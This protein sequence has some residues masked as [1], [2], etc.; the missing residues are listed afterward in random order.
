MLLRYQI[1]DKEMYNFFKRVCKN[2]WRRK[3][4]ICEECPFK[5]YVA[6]AAQM[7]A[8]THDLEDPLKEFIDL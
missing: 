1:E 4:K 2:N 5:G 3:A 6:S 8:C 7:Y